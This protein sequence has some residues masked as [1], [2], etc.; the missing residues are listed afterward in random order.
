[1]ASSSYYA[2]DGADGR[3]LLASAVCVAAF[4]LSVPRASQPRALAA[5]SA[6]AALAWIGWSYRGAASAS[7]AEQDAERRGQGGSSSNAGTT[8]DVL[9]ASNGGRARKKTSFASIDAELY[10]LRVPATAEA[11]AAWIDAPAASARGQLR[12]LALRGPLLDLVRRAARLGSRNG[13]SASGVRAKAALE[14]FFARYGRAM[15]SRDASY[16]ARTLD[17]LRDTR[18]VALNALNDVSLSVPPSLGRRALRAIDAA[19]EETLRCMTR[20]AERHAP[21]RLPELAAAA[22]RWAAPAPADGR[23]S[24][25]ELF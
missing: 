9:T 3:A 1:M 24:C 14:D 6:L 10:T 2:L 16:A 5:L 25:R 13:N 8:S 19:R 11:R 23:R 21:S 7:A 18:A 12:N 17:V 15:L 20:L 22:A 4:L